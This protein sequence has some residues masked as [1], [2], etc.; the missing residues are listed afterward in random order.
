MARRVPEWVKRNPGLALA[1]YSG[2]LKRARRRYG[3]D[4]DQALAA[5]RDYGNVLY[6][7]GEMENAVAELSAVIDRRQ[8]G[9]ADV[10]DT[11]LREAE[12]QREHM[13]L[14]MGRLEEVEQICRSLSEKYDR[15][16]GLNHPHSIRVHE[17]HAVALGEM[18]RL[19]EAE[20]ELAD[21]VARRASRGEGD[22]A[23]VLDA[24]T[25]HAETLWALGR[26][27]EAEI[28]WS[29]L[30]EIRER[31]LGKAHAETLKAQEKHANTLYKLGMREKAATE[32]GEI[33][34]LFASNLGAD[35]A[36][37]QRT[38]GW[39]VRILRELSEK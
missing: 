16:L 36:D 25:S 26:Y 30:A 3:P 21:V 37:A 11:F 18:G 19:Q 12:I 22:D 20:L 15:G 7:C 31:S 29:E 6:R 1:I 5:R 2:K 4:S 10:E 13:M 33:A 9:G 8:A 23:A 35:S 27:A 32:Y 14:K 28:V 24:R 39:Q 17:D 34:A 38:R